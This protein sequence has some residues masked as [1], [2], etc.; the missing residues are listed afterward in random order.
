MSPQ[1][2]SKNPVLAIVLTVVP[3][4]GQVYV[5]RP[6]KAVGLLIITA[7]IIL[8][9][10]FSD[11]YLMRLIMANI[12]LVTAVPAAAEAYQ[13]AKYGKNTIDTGAR[14]YVILL[15]ISTGFSAIPLLWQ[16]GRFSRKVKIAWTVAVPVLAVIFFTTLIR[17]WQT[18]ETA[19]RELFH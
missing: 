7:G 15:L 18:L 3:G 5:G 10:I 17:Y 19:L 2:S 12:Y 13:I 9:L 1:H 11:S 16:S 4:M 8:T 6:R 14:W